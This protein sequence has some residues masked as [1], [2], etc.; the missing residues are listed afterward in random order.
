VAESV[1][2]PGSNLFKPESTE[3]LVVHNDTAAALAN[4]DFKGNM[5]PGS[6]DA[7]EG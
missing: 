4:I 2:V 5:L 3:C 1:Q 6:P 7:G